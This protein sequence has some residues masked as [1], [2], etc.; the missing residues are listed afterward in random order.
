MSISAIYEN[1]RAIALNEFN[2]I[3]TAGSVLRLPSGEA[4]KLRLQ[5][6]DDS[7]LEVNIS[8]TGRYSYHW[9][10]RLIGRTDIYRFD[11]APH[12]A[13]KAVASY[14]AHFHNGSDENVEASPISRDLAEA[15]RQVLGFVRLK[16]YEEQQKQTPQDV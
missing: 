7:F 8:V 13:W 12:T 14:P 11:N 16:L 3:I 5:L 9:E 4:L 6:I 2:D 15:I 1:Q 10:R